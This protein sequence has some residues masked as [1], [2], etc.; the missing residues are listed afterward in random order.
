MAKNS[1]SKAPADGQ[2]RMR[3][4]SSAMHRFSV[5]LPDVRDWQIAETVA[6]D[7]LFT[8]FISFDDCFRRR[9]RQNP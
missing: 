4:H 2:P 6:G 8:G 3:G 1:G 7:E 9:R 5:K